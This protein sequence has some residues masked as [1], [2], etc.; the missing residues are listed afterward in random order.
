MG[1]PTS[2]PLPAPRDPP[3]PWVG[4]ARATMGRGRAGSNHVLPRRT[5]LASTLLPQPSATAGSRW[6]RP[7]FFQES[8]SEGS[9]AQALISTCGLTH[10]TQPQKSGPGIPLGA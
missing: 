5:R 2:Y 4:M 1:H 6:C 8:S 7:L 10:T 3:A 9:P